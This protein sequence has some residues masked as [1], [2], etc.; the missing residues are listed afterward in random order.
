MDENNGFTGWIL[1]GVGAIVSTLAGVITMFYRTQISDYKTHATELKIE[2]DK[3]QKRAD[4]CEKDHTESKVRI[5]VL[6][7]RLAEVEKAL[8]RQGDL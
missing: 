4:Q 3:F 5:A 6:E 7:S 8:K 2:I 1:A